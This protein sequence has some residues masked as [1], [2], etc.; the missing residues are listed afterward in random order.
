MPAFEPPQMTYKKEKAW[1]HTAK[2]GF[3]NPK[4]LWND[5]WQR[6]NTMAVPILDEDAFFA[7]AIAA[8]N[9]AENREHL[10]ELLAKKHAERRRDLENVVRDI[11]LSSISLQQQY[12]S[13]HTRD[14]ALKIG[15]TGSLDSFI[16]FVCGVVFGWKGSEKGEPLTQVSSADDASVVDYEANIQGSSG[17]QDD[18]LDAGGDPWEHENTFPPEL[19]SPGW[20]EQVD[21][22][23]NST[24]WRVAECHDADETSS[25]HRFQAPLSMDTHHKKSIREGEEEN[26]TERNDMER[27]YQSQN[28]SPESP[29][30]HG[31]SFQPRPLSPRPTDS[32]PADT[33]TPLSKASQS[34]SS[35][36][37][38]QAISPYTS[39]SSSELSDVQ[40][41]D[42]SYP[43][44]KQDSPTRPGPSEQPVGHTQSS[45]LAAGPVITRKR[46]FLHESDGEDVDEGHERR[47]RR[48]TSIDLGHVMT[49]VSPAG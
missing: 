43:Q 32:T 10:E 49:S 48:I 39:P 33:A 3:R 37:A 44:A 20:D 47:K 12:P 21:E 34:A 9:C 24:L 13:T 6:F 14:A 46:S 16:Q 22:V 36:H 1:I 7:D 42:K 2:P 17:A 5:Y 29:I 18:A 27:Q 35:P 25:E 28:T 4:I 19:Y 8:A 38:L 41:V 31:S 23:W 30:N 40:G 45:G 26:E 11:A 15:Q